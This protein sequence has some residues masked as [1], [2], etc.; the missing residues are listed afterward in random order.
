MS[1]VLQT[2]IDSV[3]SILEMFSSQSAL[4]VHEAQ[5]AFREPN[6]KCSLAYITSNFGWIP[7]K[8]KK[9]E[10]SGLSLQESMDILED[11]KQKL[12]TVK[13]EVGINVSRKFQAVIDRNP[14]TLLSSLCERS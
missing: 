10:S 1:S 11:V 14:P 3:K 8:I 12:S 6:M 13:G 5:A 2:A 4:S 7:E 9:L